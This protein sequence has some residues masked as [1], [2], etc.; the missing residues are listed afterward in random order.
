MALQ[1]HLGSARSLLDVGSG[2][3]FPG[4]PLAVSNPA[5]R[6]TLVERN[7]KKCS[8]LRHVVMTLK[9]SNVHVINAD[10]RDI[11]EE[12]NPFDAISARAVAS[13]D[14][15]WT[16]CRDMLTERGRLLLQTAASYD[17]KLQG[18]LVESHPSSGIGWIGV[19]RR[20]ES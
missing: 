8:F 15:I 12:L 19:V 20:I 9:L 3:G 1:E 16:W 18:A 17:G 13:P 4:I 6:T 14:Q 7:H 2:G 11:E 5:I 10:I